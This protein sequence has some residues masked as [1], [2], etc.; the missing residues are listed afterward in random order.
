MKEKDINAA[1]ARKMAGVA[2]QIDEE[3]IKRWGN[4]NP[5]NK[6]V[7]QILL[8]QEVESPPQIDKFKLLDRIKSKMSDPDQEKVV[9][10]HITGNQRKKWWPAIAAAIAII[11]IASISVIQNQK[12]FDVSVREQTELVRKTNP[13]GQKSTIFL[14]DG[15][16]V[17]LNSG[18]SLSYVNGFSQPERRVMLQGEAYFI[19]AKDPSRPFKVVTGDIITTAVGTEFNVNSYEKDVKVSLT[20][21][22][23]I[24]SNDNANWENALEPGQEISYNHNA[25]EFMISSFDLY[26]TLAWK[27]GL[28][29]FRNASFAEIKE[30][31]ERWYG[32][33]IEA[34]TSEFEDWSITAEFDNESLD[35]VLQSLK[36]AKKIDYHINKTRVKI[37]NQ[38]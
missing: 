14:N 27:N 12:F 3:T 31:L 22:K 2:S 16:K 26:E 24:V 6:K 30:S 32:V 8:N 23:V 34:D 4:E 37:S 28:L 21:G 1:I 10:M 15:T 29:L 18:S 25:K 38:E 36:F 20:E 13:K 33:D 17:F 5:S 9:P 19:I 11:I 7:L 35:Y